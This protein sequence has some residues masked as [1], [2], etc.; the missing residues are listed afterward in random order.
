MR[1][2]RAQV[3][4]YDSDNRCNAYLT[5][6]LRKARRSDRAPNFA[7]VLRPSGVAQPPS[8]K[9]RAPC[10]SCCRRRIRQNPSAGTVRVITAA[11]LKSNLHLGCEPPGENSR[12]IETSAKSS[13]TSVV[14]SPTLIPGFG[15]A[16]HPR[17]NTSFQDRFIHCDPAPQIG[18][19]HLPAPV[20]RGKTDMPLSDFQC[21]K[22]LLCIN[23]LGLDTIIAER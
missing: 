13:T 16:C 23:Q 9:R 18:D 22:K 17:I 6:V 20:D 3:L 5:I 10:A 2:S 14:G 12:A 4:R 1:A 11:R 15:P 19:L 21:P 8:A 7:V